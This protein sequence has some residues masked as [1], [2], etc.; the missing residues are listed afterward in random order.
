MDFIFVQ[1]ITTKLLPTRVEL[2]IEMVLGKFMLIINP[3]M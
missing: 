3:V 1:L 2:Q